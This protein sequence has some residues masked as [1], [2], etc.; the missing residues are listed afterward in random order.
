M[1]RNEIVSYIQSMIQ[2][3]YHSNDKALSDKIANSQSFGDLELTPP[4][5]AR[6]IMSCEEKYH[7]DLGNAMYPSIQSIVDALMSVADTVNATDNAN[8]SEGKPDDNDQLPPPPESIEIPDM[9]AAP[10]GA[11]DSTGVEGEHVPDFSDEGEGEE[12][13]KENTEETTED[14]PAEEEKSQEE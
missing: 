11:E 9:P 10:E 1:D 6:L 12:D 3:F 14:M 13:V 8:E 5:I 7:V 4:E 2:Q